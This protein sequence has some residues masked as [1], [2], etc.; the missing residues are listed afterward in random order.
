MLDYEFCI[1]DFNGTILDDVELGISSV[2]KLLSDRGLPTVQNKDAYRDTFGFP[3]VDYYKKLGFDFFSE[4]Y[5]KIAHEWVE[6]Y[7][8]NLD[9]AKLFPDVKAALDFFDSKAVRQLVLSA[10][11]KNMLIAQLNG[12]GL[13]DRFEEVLGIDNIYGDSK[14][15]LAKAWRERNPDAKVMFIGDTTHDCETAEL[16]DADCYIVSAGHHSPKRFEGK[17][18]KMFSSLGELIEYLQSELAENK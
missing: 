2:N 18:A 6:L 5:E 12:L 11:E 7:N 16:L 1:W 3:I 13:S 4:S 9:K 15:M 10:S 8:S 14:L 17:K